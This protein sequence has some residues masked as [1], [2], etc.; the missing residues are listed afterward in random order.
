VKK[1]FCILVVTLFLLL[2][3]VSAWAEPVAKE[4]LYK[5]TTTLTYPKTYT[6]RFSLW[7]AETLGTEV[8]SEEKSI[9]LT[10][11]TIKTYLG[12]TIP[13]DPADFNQQ[14]WVQVEKKKADLTYK[15]IGTRDKLV[16]GSYALWGEN[17]TAG[18]KS[19][20]FGSG[21]LSFT[22][23]LTNIT[24]LT[25]AAPG[26]GMVIFH[27]SGVMSF[28]A[29]TNGTVDEARCSISDSPST[30]ILPYSI[31][32]VPASAPDASV[33]SY[34]APL[35]NTKTFAVSAAGN[36][37]GYLNCQIIQGGGGSSAFV[38]FGEISAIYVP[39]QY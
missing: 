26:P 2:G 1:T 33:L 19:A 25:I 8:W 31:I 36:V 10:S 20:T 15:V 23:T 30:A 4:I 21:A 14:L 13:L 18:A 12:D 24:S 11:S 27:A 7:D 5:K 38:Q 34:G 32:L 16:A 6:L 3:V 22:S 28:R 35:G 39:T 17:G 29:H 37:T 9:N